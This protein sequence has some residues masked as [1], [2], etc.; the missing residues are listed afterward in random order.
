MNN[1]LLFMSAILIGYAIAAF[2]ISTDNCM[3]CIMIPDIHCNLPV[4]F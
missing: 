2:S 1:V 3:T 4:I